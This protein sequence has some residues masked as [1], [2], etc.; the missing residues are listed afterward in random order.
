MLDVAAGVLGERATLRLGRLEDPLPY[1]P[2]ELVVSAFAVHHL[3]ATAKSFLFRR[4]AERLSG[5]G[6]FVMADL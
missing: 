3:D 1:G 6:R 2:F 5:D 4:V